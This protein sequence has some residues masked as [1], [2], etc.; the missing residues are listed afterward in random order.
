[1]PSCGATTG[2]DRSKVEVDSSIQKTFRTI[3]RTTVYANWPLIF[4]TFFIGWQETS[5]FLSC[6][7]YCLA[8]PEPPKPDQWLEISSPYL[9]FRIDPLRKLDA[10]SRPPS[11]VSPGEPLNEITEQ[12]VP[13]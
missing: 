2:A 13:T 6:N 9:G 3:G 1:M 5:G 7:L 10:T 8:E 4:S 12:S 11:Y